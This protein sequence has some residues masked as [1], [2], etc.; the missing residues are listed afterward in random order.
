MQLYHVI[1]VVPHSETEEMM[2]VYGQ[3]PTSLL[4]ANGFPC[5]HL[6]PLRNHFQWWV[7]PEAMFEEMVTWPDGEVRPCFVR[8]PD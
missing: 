3:E 1:L 4:D 5:G 6:E 7:R 2:V 8:E